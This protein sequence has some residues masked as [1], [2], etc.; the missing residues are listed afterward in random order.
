MF[1]I[2]DNQAQIVERQKHRR[3]NPDH[4]L[5]LARY[6]AFPN[7]N[8]LIIRKLGV[9]NTH[10]IAKHPLKPHHNLGSQGN[11]GEQVQHLG[12]AAESLLNKVDIH[13]GFAA[14]CNTVE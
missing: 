14:A 6:D 4:K 10:L 5:I 3:P 1:F 12:A 11:F 13:F 8:P 7:L 2:H 9:V